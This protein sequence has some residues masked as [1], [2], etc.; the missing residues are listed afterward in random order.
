MSKKLSIKNLVV[1]AQ[2]PSGEWFKIVHGVD[3]EVNAGE[4]V[5][6]IGESGAGKT[7]IAL[8]GLAY[9]R[10]GTRIIGGSVHLDDVNLLSLGK[11]QRRKIRG[12]KIAYVAQ[13]ASAALNPVI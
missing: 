5:A 2:K 9:S 3:V 11:K 8:G 6:L 10:P 7:T 13:S 1:E 12:K 4:V